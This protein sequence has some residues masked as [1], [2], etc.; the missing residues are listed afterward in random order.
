MTWNI[1]THH[2]ERLQNRSHD[3]P[4]KPAACRAW[5]TG[6]RSCRCCWR[7]PWKRWCTREAG[8]WERN[9][10]LERLESAEGWKVNLVARWFMMILHSLFLDVLDGFFAWAAN[11]TQ[12]SSVA[13]C[14]YCCSNQLGVHR[15][16]DSKVYWGIDR[17]H[18]PG[19]FIIAGWMKRRQRQRWT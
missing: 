3:L 16:D 8:N 13:V 15:F 4:A 12:N 11:F 18:A 6:M 9:L 5:A 7:K 14:Q 17:N 2:A 1:A 19:N 10:W